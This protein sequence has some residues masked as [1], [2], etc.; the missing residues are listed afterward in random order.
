MSDADA[1][2]TR[3]RLRVIEV[4]QLIADAAFDTLELEHLD[5]LRA[6]IAERVGPAPRRATQPGSRIA[7]ALRLDAAIGDGEG[8]RSLDDFHLEAQIPLR[9]ELAAI[10]R[11]KP[12]AGMMAASGTNRVPWE[13]AAGQAEW[14]QGELALV[15]ARA[16]VAGS[17]RRR[18]PDIADIEIVVEPRVLD[19]GLFGEPTPDIDS[20]RAVVAKWGH[21]AKSGDRYMRVERPAGLLP[22]DVFIV[23]PPAQWGSILAIRTGPADLGRHAVTRLKAYGLRHVDGHVEDATGTTIPTP[24]EEAFFA[25]A[26]LPFLSPGARQFES[27]RVSLSSAERDAAIAAATSAAGA[28]P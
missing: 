7:L 28:V 14:L 3:L 23:T 18:R 10:L 2:F 20:I 24:T 12:T 27:A 15:T 16:K 13:A 8:D 1:R 25:L 6:A 22:V 4:G 9:E 5:A 19:A 26:G 11:S 21:V 17:V